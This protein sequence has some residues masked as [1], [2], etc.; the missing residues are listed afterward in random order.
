[1]NEDGFQ[2][3]LIGPEKIALAC[4]NIIPEMFLEVR[5]CFSVSSAISSLV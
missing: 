4:Q 1:M 5:H 2:F 3:T